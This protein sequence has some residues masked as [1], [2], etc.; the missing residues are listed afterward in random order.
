MN[1][2]RRFVTR[3]LAGGALLL[4]LGGCAA[5]GPDFSGPGRVR[6]PEKWRRNRSAKDPRLA[7]WWSIYRDRNLDRLV[8]LAW[9]QNLDLKAAGLRILQA[10]A[11]LGIAEGMAFPQVQRVSGSA[12]VGDADRGAPSVRSLSTAFD[13]GWELDLWGRY[14]R[15]AESAEAT[16]Y[17]AVASYNDI[18]VTVIAEVARN[19]IAY[20]TAQER[21][22]YARRNI[23]IQE[24]V[25][26]VTEIQFNSGNVSELDMQQARTQLHSTRSAVYD[27]KLSRVRAR[28]ALAMLLGLNP[29]EVERYLG[30]REYRDRFEGYV[31]KEKGTIQIKEGGKTALGVSLIPTPRFDP[32]RP[33]DAEL[34]TRRPDVKAAE[35]AAHARSAEI[36]IA[37]ADLYPSFSL[38][39]NITYADT[40]LSKLSV[41][42]GPSFAWNI[43]QYGRIRNK[44]RL[45][46]AAFEESLVQYNKRVLTA[47]HEVSYA[48]DNYRYTLDQL[49]ES[50]AAVEASVRAFNI[51]M[52]Q[53]NDGLVSYQRLLNSVEKLTRFQD[54]HARLKGALATQVAL[55]YKALGGGWQISRGGRY[56]SEET[57]RRMKERSDWGRMLEGDAVRLPKGWER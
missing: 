20:R 11:A 46:D 39:G 57:V 22:A 38:L 52:R 27:L 32:R 28:N 30:R 10:R 36:G 47:V 23:A 3:T 54:Q 29:T 37:A 43:F 35:Y 41:V 7:S 33:I 12:T 1:G 13:L 25:V 24:Y 42:A 17:A 53:Y 31:R 55:L 19:Y 4:G 45:K 40:S 48:L 51:S 18:L 56:L 2:R 6:L 15:G 44:I 34:I 8:S 21:I 16:L 49:K 5:V 26:K 50:E 14:A 9:K